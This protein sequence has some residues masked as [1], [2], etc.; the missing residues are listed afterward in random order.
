MVYK[1]TFTSRLGAPSSIDSGLSIAT[2][3]CSTQRS[4]SPNNCQPRKKK[5]LFHPITTSDSEGQVLPKRSTDSCCTI[6]VKCDD[7]LR[8]F[9]L[10]R[11]AFEQIAPPIRAKLSETFLLSMAC[12][13]A[14]IIISI[15]CHI[16]S[17]V[18][19]GKAINLMYNP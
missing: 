10:M 9:S 16:N 7:A 2:F 15:K 3:D 13:S 1:P 14:S 17:V 4:W 19:H 18:D 6:T 12:Y 11:R 5:K 8:N